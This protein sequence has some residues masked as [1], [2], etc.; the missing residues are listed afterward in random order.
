M[1]GGRGGPSISFAGPSVIQSTKLKPG[2]KPNPS[3][4]LWAA[5]SP[6]HRGVA[7]RIEDMLCAM[8]YALRSKPRPLAAGCWLYTDHGH[9]SR[10]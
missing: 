2:F 8:R 3:S 10:V 4:G 5:P 6:L 1:H 9:S 7:K